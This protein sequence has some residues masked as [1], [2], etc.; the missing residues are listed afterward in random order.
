MVV[1]SLKVF[2]FSVYMSKWAVRTAAYTGEA[3][4]SLQCPCPSGSE[5]LTQAGLFSKLLSLYLVSILPVCAT[6]AL[7]IRFYP[8][9]EVKGERKGARVAAA[10]AGVT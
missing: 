2:F 8:D 3:S 10:V 6:A 9:N 4:V 5:L 1:D 7:S